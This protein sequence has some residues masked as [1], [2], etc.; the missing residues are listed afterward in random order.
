MP[1][2]PEDDFGA[3]R[4]TW[5]AALCLAALSATLL[6]VFHAGG[7][8]TAG[9]AGTAL[10][11]GLAGHATTRL[12]T[13]GPGGGGGG[14]PDRL[15][16]T[17]GALALGVAP[18]LLV[19]VAAVLAA[20][21]LLLPAEDVRDQA[22]SALWT[23]GGVGGLQSLGHASRDAGTSVD[24][25]W[26]GWL[27]GVGFQLAL[28]WSLLV[29]LLRRPSILVAVAVVGAVASLALDMA[30]RREG[31]DLRADHLA[32]PRAWPFLLGAIAALVPAPSGHRLPDVLDPVARLGAVAVPFYLW[33][34]PCLA[35]PRLILARPLTVAEILFALGA[36]LLFAWLTLRRIERP[37]R[38]RLEG[39][40]WTTL[41][42]AGSAL[43]VAVGVA[44][45]VFALDGL[46]GRGWGRAQPAESMARPPLQ[47]ACHTEGETLP[48]AEACTVPA[49]AAADIVL[50]GN[51]HADHLSPAVLAWGAERGWGVRQAT[52]SG[53]L[54]VLRSG[55]RLANAGCLRFNRAAVAEWAGARPRVILLGAAW[56]LLLD[57]SA[58]IDVLIGEMDHTVRTL[59][60]QLGPETLIVLLGTTPDHAFAPARCRA[61]RQ[62]LGLDPAPCDEAE[63]ANAD[64][65]RSVD[66]RLA[67]LAAA[68]PGVAF[69]SS[70]EVLCPDGPCRTRGAGGAWYADRSH[71]TAAGGAAQT[72]ALAGLLD[73]RSPRAD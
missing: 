10:A 48:P 62:F 60:A 69:Y 52:R 36:A 54:P 29:V 43:A 49:G 15:A 45:G 20:A 16:R 67:R 6:A 24:L 47:A 44:A 70:W 65:A 31:F 14:T 13:A 30:L 8:E 51:S 22:W 37:L 25:L 55:S 46:P 68:R 7:G 39:R 17:W 42:A 3:V 40:P 32:P 27:V 34:W 18:A 23:V 11:L 71:L 63:A 64:L 72:G 41:A 19:V 21:I 58:D 73:A 53:C 2:A 38:R 56:T 12:A 26:H 5:R 9:R 57:D 66:G 33:S 1:F 59:R 28:G 4:Q 50:W 61:R 35:L